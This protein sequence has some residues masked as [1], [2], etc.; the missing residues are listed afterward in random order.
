MNKFAFITMDVE[1]FF[2]TGCIRR[3]HI[4]PDERYDCAEKIKDFLVYLNKNNIKATL[5]VT[6]D[7]I[8]RCKD[9]LVTAI[10]HG[11]EIALHALHH[12]KV[13][14]MSLEEFEESLKQAKEIIKK[15]LGVEI[16]GNRFPHFKKTD[17][18]IEILKNN[19]FLFDSGKFINKKHDYKKINDLVYEKDGFYEFA[20]VKT[21]Y[22]LFPINASGGGF[23]R[24][25]PWHT[26]KRKVKKHLKKSDGYLLYLHPFEIYEGKLPKYKKLNPLERMFVQLFRD[27][28]MNKIDTIVSLLKQE[29]FQFVTMSEYIEKYGR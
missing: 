15:E 17:K 13:S 10:E 6:V 18:H 5:F 20:L 8:H 22:C 14:E 9:Y 23:L 2:D 7:F 12:K 21:R 3:H 28:Y 26:M 24:L 19:G 29:N 27:T 1:S 25:I 11:H 4:E 16:K